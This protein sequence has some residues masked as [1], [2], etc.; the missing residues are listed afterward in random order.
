[1]L[2]YLIRRALW[3]LLLFVAVTLVTYLIFFV[4]P[5]NPGRLVCGGQQAQS[6]C[7]KRATENLGLNK[8]IIVQYG[9]FLKHLVVDQSLGTSFINR[10]SVNTVVAGA[11]PVTAALVFGGMI[12]WLSIGLCVGI[13]SALRPRSLLD[14][15]AMVFVLVGVSAH[16]IWIGLLFSYIFGFKLGWFPITG[17]SD[18]FN[19]AEGTIGGPWPWFYHMILPWLTFGILGAALYVRMIRANVIETMS[20]DYVRTARSKGAPESR[21]M[22]SHILRNALLPIVTIL[23]M[24]VGISLGG[25]IFTETVYSLPG[26]GHIAINAVGNYDLPVVQGVVV[27]ATTAIIGFNLFVDIV[28]AWVDPRIRLE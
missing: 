21:V 1:M 27:F 2:R 3:A 14:R 5:T 24:D 9:I 22:R 4:A 10:Q 7:I 11:A 13:F 17:Y 6:D 8:P 12:L 20:E 15:G 16:P 19:P 26:L 23:G 25:A 28:Y 18:F